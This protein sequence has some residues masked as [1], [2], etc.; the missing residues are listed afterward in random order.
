[1]F[2]YKGEITFTPAHAENQTFMELFFEYVKRRREPY[3]I[4]EVSS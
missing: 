1:M 2:D 3:H 4:D